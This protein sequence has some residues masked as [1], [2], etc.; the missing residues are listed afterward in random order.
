VPQSSVCVVYKW[1]RGAGWHGKSSFKQPL[2]LP[3]LACLRDR[4]N[5]TR[6]LQGVIRI[7]EGKSQ[8]HLDGVVRASV[9]KTLNRLLDAEADELCRARRYERSPERVD[10]RAC[11]P[12]VD[13]SPDGTR[14]SR[15]MVPRHR[16][17]RMVTAPPWGKPAACPFARKPSPAD[18]SRQQRTPWNP[19]RHPALSP[20]W[21]RHSAS[22]QDPRPSHALGVPRDVPPSRNPFFP[23]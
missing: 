6:E 18:S 19:A 4:C 3:G 21:P 13:P 1:S 9:E 20:P 12:L 11:R 8:E 17:N 7:E 16:Q 2:L 14:P 5:G 22:R 23:R 10:S 15:P